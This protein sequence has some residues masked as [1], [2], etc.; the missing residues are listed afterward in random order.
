M[1][2]QIHSQIDQSLLASVI[3]ATD[4][5]ARL[6]AAGDDEI[7]QVSLLCAQQGKS[8]V[9]HRHRPQER[10]TIGTVESWI[11]IKGHMQV[12]IFDLDQKPLKSLDLHDGDCFV[13]YRGGH[14]FTVVSDQ[15]IFYE[16][17]NGP[18]RGTAA[19]LERF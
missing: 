5:T 7:L 2:Q 4:Q 3:S 8:L 18:Y 17:K 6:D 13:L 12:Q 16:I 19:D 15:T 9:P 10:T 11:V 1:L 14:A